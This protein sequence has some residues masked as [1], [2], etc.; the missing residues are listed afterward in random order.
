MFGA[1][2]I[3][4]TT[5]LLPLITLLAGAGCVSSR[6][7]GIAL[8]R[9]EFTEPQMGLPFRIVL[10]ARDGA[11]A[12]AASRAAFARISE[13]N[14]I[15]SDYDTDSE[16]S[17]LS[18]SSGEGRAMPVSD[19]LWL[20]LERALRFSAETG[21][22]FDVTVG[23]YVNLWRKA[24]RE[25]QLPRSDLLA[26]AR[27]AVGWRKVKLDSKRHT[28]TLLAPDM[29][30][31]L[32][33]IAKGYA[34]DEALKALRRHGINRALVTG[35]GD[36]AAGDAPPGKRGWRITLAPLDATNSPPARY[37]LLANAGLGTSGDLFQHIEINGRRYSHIIDPRTG[38]GLIDHS[39]VTVIARDCITANSLA[40]SASVLGPERSVK[41]IE[42]TRGAAMHLVRKPGDTIEQVETSRFRR[43]LDP[44]REN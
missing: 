30:L 22:A 33:S 38:Y 8:E 18:R 24:R 40:T 41:L 10:Y 19:D 6:N 39:L 34:I 26:V 7:D 31:D 44:D 3:P 14:S 43:F 21:G 29:R 32:G 5:R 17:K 16:L 42:S 35:G 20:V 2:I 13:L 25:K 11:E 36:M 9:F 28:A 27:D 23:P 15:L 4:L 37:I 1:H 12:G